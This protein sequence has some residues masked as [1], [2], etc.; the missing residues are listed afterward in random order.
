[1]RIPAVGDG[2]LDRLAVR[3]TTGQIRK[4]D[5][6]AAA[7]SSV[8]RRTVKR[9]SISLITPSHRLDKRDKAADV[10]RLDWPVRWDR[11]RPCDGGMLE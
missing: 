6:V 1:L 11:Q 4:L 5:Q 10:N 2:L 7:F 8:R 9:Y 3:H